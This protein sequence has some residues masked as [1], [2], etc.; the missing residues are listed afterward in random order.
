MNQ[1]LINS[2]KKARKLWDEK[3]YNEAFE[4]ALSNADQNH[5]ESQIFVGNVYLTG[6]AGIE[7]N[8][9][10]AVKWLD[11]SAKSGSIFGHYLLG[12]AYYHLADYSKAFNE[13]VVAS[14]M[15]YFPAD[16]HIGRMYYEG[17]GVEKDIDK[18]YQYCLAAKKQ[19]HMF[20]SRH[21]ASMLM[22][23]HKGF[24]NRIKGMFLL[25]ET[26]IKAFFI[27]LKN[28]DSEKLYE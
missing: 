25:I 21:V 6:E 15:N 9:H 5:I 24:A 3:H 12:I 27:A 17:I 10:E 28:P 4:I 1:E 16:Y 18:S 14:K 22:K 7:Q 13:F 20:A 23:G 11:R 2:I 19:G 26:I 8:L